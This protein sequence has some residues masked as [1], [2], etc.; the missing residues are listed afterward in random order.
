MLGKK[1]LQE[2]AKK[3]SLFEWVLG[4]LG[5][6]IWPATHNDP[7]IKGPS[8]RIFTTEQAEAIEKSRQNAVD[9][10]NVPSEVEG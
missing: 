3:K 9:D 6:K 10:D 2:K 7:R 5:Y 8:P 4:L 1:R